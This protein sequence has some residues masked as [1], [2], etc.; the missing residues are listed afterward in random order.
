MKVDKIGYGMGKK[1]F[2]RL[3]C[4][5]ASIGETMPEKGRPAFE[6]ACQA[7]HLGRVSVAEH[8]V[9]QGIVHAW[10]LQGWCR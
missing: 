3:N 5:R 8:C 2:S 9:Q 1:T 10:S 6:E 4:I 7:G